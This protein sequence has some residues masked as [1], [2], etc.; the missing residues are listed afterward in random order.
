MS[1]HWRTRNLMLT[2]FGLSMALAVGAP[3]II[4][5]NRD[6]RPILSDNC[7]ACHGPDSQQRKANLRLDRQSD[8]LAD[9]DGAF[10]VVPGD[11]DASALI[12]RIEA[13]DPSEVMPPADHRK[14]LTDEERRVL[15]QWID[16]GA[17]WE[18]H[19]AYLP[20]RRP[21]VPQVEGQASGPIDSFVLARLEE[22]GVAPSPL[23]DERTL[24]RRLYLDLLG[25]PP[26]PEALNR[27]LSK[28]LAE[29]YAQLVGTLLASPAYG[30]RMAI[31]WLD[32]VRYA[33]SNGYHADLEW[34]VS[35]FRDYVID[36]FNENKPFDVFTI[37]QIAGDLLP[38][39]GLAQ[40]IAAGYNRLNMKSTEFGIQDAEYLV[41]YQGDRVR[42]TATTWLGSTLGCA[43][44]HDHKFD[45]F[46]SKDY[47]QFAAFFADIK[48][49]GYYPDAQR[50]GWGERFPVPPGEHWEPLA[51]LEREI[52]TLEEQLLEDRPGLDGGQSR[53]EA[54]VLAK[55]PQA[56][57]PIS[58]DA[59]AEWAYSSQEPGPRWRSLDFDEAT[60]RRGQGVFGSKGTPKINIRTE[61][62]SNAIW[63]RR[64]FELASIPR[65]AYLIV[66]HDEDAEVFLN[67]HL[68]GEFK[69][70]S[71]RY[72]SRPLK[73]AQRAHL[74]IGRNVLAAHCR[75][76][77][78]GQAIDVGLLPHSLAEEDSA[79]LPEGIHRTLA[80]PRDQRTPKELEAL[81]HHYRRHVASDREE[82]RLKLNA[83]QREQSALSA[84]ERTMLATVSVE[85]REVRLLP[86]G[87]WMDRSGS[88]VEPAFPHTLSPL[89]SPEEGLTRLDLANWIA[90]RDNPLTA[91]V[92]VNRLW[93]QFFGTGLSKVLDDLGAQGEWPSHPALLDWLAAEFMGSGWGVK[94][95]VRLVV[96][97][98]TYR[99]SSL[100]H[101]DLRVREMDPHNR[102]LAR[103]SRFRLDAETIRDQ[104]LAVS[105]LLVRDV[106]G[107]SVKPYQPAG[108]WDNLYFPKRVYEHDTGQGQYRRGA[109]MH[110]Q[111]QFL[112]PALLA[113]DAP[114]REEC[115]AERPR[116]NT[117]LAALVMLN[118]PSQMD[119]AQA[120]ALRLVRSDHALEARLNQLGPAVLARALRPAE[121]LALERLY[122][123]HLRDYGGDPAAVSA[124]LDTPVLRNQA[125][126]VGPD[127]AAMTSVVRAVMNLHETITRN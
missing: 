59:G 122:E 23:A 120:L 84:S 18:A 110:W 38:G 36:S 49:R 125:V 94:H 97:S 44:C 39:A 68:L 126:P 24:I 63:L 8:A 77:S 43:E 91:R 119:A 115:T 90:S 41:K 61:W 6:V 54:A 50:I 95:M 113:F 56:L 104:A 58:R 108:Y 78:G 99:Q 93:R 19:W 28:P 127:L 37:E 12:Q 92:F 72:V 10:A 116:S 11:P 27:W 80:K 35:P 55:R 34:S 40:R 101:A 96:T 26:P 103:Q 7:Y 30:E 25:L 47:Y 32:L 124:L 73:P 1:R 117:P 13:T 2:A 64:S 57:S 5:Y 20:I 60:W 52:A 86:R 112:H 87:D 29:H 53:W 69:G 123:R 118:D 31:P 42:T 114:P 81:A 74:R 106:G 4:Q 107:P 88:V 17:P 111:R 65:T 100:P 51:E 89:P 76:T 15:R 16:Q 75:Q 22:R 48:G 33:D 79:D 66:N 109:Y 70:F 62:T 98:R 45:P 82:L 121:R 71:A 83:L 3:P 14:R 85:P 67:G 21:E 105:G 102:L 9:R 46:T